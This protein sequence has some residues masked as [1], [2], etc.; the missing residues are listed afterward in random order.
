MF[1]LL[2]V[3]I[4]GAVIA[5]ALGF[6][7]IAAGATRLARLAFALLAAGIAAVAV[8]VAMGSPPF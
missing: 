5:G 2:L 6:S 7:G 8:T 1:T 4:I 3:L